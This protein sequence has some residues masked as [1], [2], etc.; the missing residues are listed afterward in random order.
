MGEVRAGP[1]QVFR[2][3][4]ADDLID[5]FDVQHVFG[6]G[7]KHRPQGYDILPPRG[8]V[9]RY[10]EPV[11][12]DDAQVDP[13]FPR[14]GGDGPGL[15]RN[16]DGEGVEEGL[17]FYVEAEPFQPLGHDPGHPVDL[18]GDTP[19]AIGAMINRV[20]A[21]QDRQQDLG[22]ADVGGRLFAANVLFAGLQRH[23]QRRVASGVH[24]DA[25]N[26]PRHLAFVNVPGGEESGMGAAI[27]HRHAEALRRSDDDV[28][29]HLAGWF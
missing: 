27:S 28:G 8:F 21:G 5:R 3:A 22:G 24:R 16:D 15:A 6:L 7:R 4:F 1:D 13:L 17:G 23:A 2:E 12:V 19:E 25:D 14:P 26:A 10:A 11:V 29:A 9:E 20:K 18:S